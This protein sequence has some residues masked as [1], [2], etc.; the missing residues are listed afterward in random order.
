MPTKYLSVIAVLLLLLQS[1]GQNKTAELSRTWKIQN[2]KYDKEI[3]ETLKPTVEQSIAQMRKSFTLTYNPNGT[4]HSDF[5]G[6][7][8][9]GKW[10]LNWNSSTITSTSND[11]KTK[12]YQVKELTDKSF[13]FEAEEGGEKVIFEMIP[14]TNEENTK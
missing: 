10:K 11:G 2:L 5:D 6:Q 1:C 4:Y 9:D 8:L 7:K 12:T 14:A 3:P 13:V